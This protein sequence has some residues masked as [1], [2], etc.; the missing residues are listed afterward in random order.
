MHGYDNRRNE[1]QL[2][3]LKIFPPV[4]ATSFTLENDGND[5]KYHYL[6]SQSLMR[7]PNRHGIDGIAYLSTKVNNE[8]QFPQGV[9]LTIPATDISNNRIYSQNLKDPR[10]QTY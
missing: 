10:Y 5:C 9:N 2:S 4:I 8:F 7:V 1:L 3:M 6:L